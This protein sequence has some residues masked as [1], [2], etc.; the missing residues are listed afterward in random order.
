MGHP[1]EKGGKGYAG[2]ESTVSNYQ[3]PG[4]Q[5]IESEYRGSDF[6]VLKNVLNMGKILRAKRGVKS[7]S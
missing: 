1:P 6:R 2:E 4:C 7:L 3:L 5:L